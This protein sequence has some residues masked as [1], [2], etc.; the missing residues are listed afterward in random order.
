MRMRQGRMVLL[1]TSQVGERGP[2]SSAMKLA[3]SGWAVVGH[4]S[5]GRS[6][7]G[8]QDG[9]S[10]RGAGDGLEGTSEAGGDVLA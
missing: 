10:G 1:T 6:V 9:A 8:S 2:T 3:G 5:V 7:G 4:R